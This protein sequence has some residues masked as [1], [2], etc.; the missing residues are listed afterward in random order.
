MV[1]PLVPVTPM[2]VALVYP[3]ANSISEIMGILFSLICFTISH[4]LEIPGLFTI[5]SAFKILS[6]ECP[7]SSYSIL[8]FLKISMVLEQILSESETNTFHKYFLAN[9]AA[10]SPLS[11]APKTI[12]FFII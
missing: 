8:L 3:N 6:D 7:N 5:K 11:P 4:S 1:F 12:K 2:I 9:K 10:P